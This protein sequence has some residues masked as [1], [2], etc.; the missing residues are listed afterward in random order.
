MSHTRGPWTIEYENDEGDMYEDGV[1]IDSPEGPVAFNV[2]ECSAN[3]IAAAPD[4]LAAL[5]DVLASGDW[6]GDGNFVIPHKPHDSEMD[7]A[8]PDCLLQSRAAIAKA[9]GRGE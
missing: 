2:I 9:E 4:L 7:T 3:V 6:D 5:K 8:D 1:R